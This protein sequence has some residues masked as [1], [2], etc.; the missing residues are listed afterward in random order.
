MRKELSNKPLLEAIFEL[1]W[2]LKEIS[3][4]VKVDPNYKLLLGMIYDRIKDE[5]PYYE[6]LPTATMPDEMAGHVIQNRFRTNENEWPVFQIGPGIITVNDTQGYVWDDFQKRINDIIGILHEVYPN[7]EENLKFESV[8]LRYLDS[9]EFNFENNNIFDFLKD[10]MKTHVKFYDKLFDGTGVE[11]SPLGFDF[12]TSFVCN[13][14][15]GAMFLRFGRV[16]IN[17]SDNLMWETMVKSLYGDT[18][19]KQED[20]EVWVNEAHD[21]TDDWFF[22][23]IDGNLMRRFE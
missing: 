20:L 14:P 16:N 15:K 3:E 5:Y 2:K 18:P 21:L 23:L 11:S 12:K 4:G 6:E 9:I 17:S 10:E 7:S 8:S 1:K 22:K 19:Q 13:N